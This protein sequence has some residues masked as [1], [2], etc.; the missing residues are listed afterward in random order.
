VH[1]CSSAYPDGIPKGQSM[2]LSL[3]Y[4]LDGTFLEASH[5]FVPDTLTAGLNELGS[6]YGTSF[7]VAD[8]TLANLI[9]ELSGFWDETHDHG[10]MVVAVHGQ[11]DIK[12]GTVDPGPSVQLFTFTLDA[13]YVTSDAILKDA[14]AKVY[15]LVTHGWSCNVDIMTPNPTRNF[16]DG[17]SPWS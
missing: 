4:Q 9:I 14:A 15:Y 1:Y 3:S 6:A 7:F 12:I 5:E 17:P 2:K 11:E 10:G 16:G 8:G 13:L